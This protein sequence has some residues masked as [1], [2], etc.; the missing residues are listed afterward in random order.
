MKL[1]VQNKP[2][3]SFTEFII[4]IY[5]NF[6]PV[7]MTRFTQVSIHEDH[8]T[9]DKVIAVFSRL[10]TKEVLMHDSKVNHFIN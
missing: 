1:T 7:M 6:Y 10:A 8:K 3:K 2:D 4:L 5:S 9:H